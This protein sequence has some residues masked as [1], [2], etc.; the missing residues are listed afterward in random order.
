MLLAEEGAAEPTSPEMLIV[1]AVEAEAAAEPAPDA[2]SELPDPA[3]VEAAPDPED[4]G[5]LSDI[6]AENVEADG[7]E[8]ADPIAD[9]VVPSEPEAAMPAAQP[10]VV[11]V[12]EVGAED[13][14]ALAFP[15][16][17]T[18]SI[19]EKIALFA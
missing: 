2:V 12:A 17:D 7:I 11:A 10:L 15:D 9:L 6:D 13:D 4:H 8:E 16:L 5:I 14:L 1:E 19:E 3:P 18:L